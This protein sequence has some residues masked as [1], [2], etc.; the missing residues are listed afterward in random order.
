MLVS[1]VRAVNNETQDLMLTMMY[2]VP[3]SGAVLFRNNEHRY[4]RETSWLL[5]KPD[6]KYTRQPFSNSRVRNINGC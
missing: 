6:A 4:Y 3:N 2:G 5:T 1:W